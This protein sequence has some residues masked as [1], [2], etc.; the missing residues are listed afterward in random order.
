MHTRRLLTILGFALLSASPLFAQQQG[1]KL[2]GQGHPFTADELP[3]GELKTKLQNLKPQARGE[4]MKWLHSFTFPAS[5]A[6]KFLGR[7]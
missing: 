7:R 1:K 3:N 5:D 4:A 6:A 2:F